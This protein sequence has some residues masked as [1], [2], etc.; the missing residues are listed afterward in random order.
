MLRL[1]FALSLLLSALV[2]GSL[3]AQT[4]A[5]DVLKAQGLQGIEFKNYV[6]PHKVIESR[7]SIQGIGTELGRQI[8]AGALHAEY[9]QKYRIVR[10]HDAAPDKLSADLL[11]L[12][13]DA[14]VDNIRNLNWIVS[15]YL[16]QEFGYAPADADLLSDFVTRYNAFY[17]GKLD[18]IQATFIPA[19]G[20]NVTAENA[21]IALSY[22][23]WPGKT[24]LLIP[25]R[26]SL[27]KGLAGGLNTEEVS[28][29]EIVKSMDDQPALDERKKL[30]DLKEAEIVQEQKAIVQAETKA[31]T[32]PGTTPPS[33]TTNPPA[34]QASTAPAAAPATSAPASAP[35]PAATPASAAAPVATPTPAPALPLDQAKQQLAARDQALQAERQDIVQQETKATPAPAPTPAPTK[36]ASTAAFVKMTEGSKTG[37]L[38][39]LDTAADKV[40][41]KSQVNSIRQ[42]NAPS[43]GAG[44][45]VVAGD[46]KVDNGAIRLLILSPDD[47]A[48][49]ATGTDD[50]VADTP[51]VISGNQVLALVK[52]TS[53]LV[54]AAFDTSLKT[55]AKGTDAL[56]SLTDVV[57]TASGIYVQ[58]AGGTVLLL[59]PTTLKKKAALGE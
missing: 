49:L 30:A 24:R 53:G 28:N 17:R 31:P 50:V 37:Q 4:V 8:K 16:Q 10:V 55:V 56:S 9:G 45:L 18:Y 48:I 58:A 15:A 34:A 59:D 42:S 41:K 5:E 22:T 6:G 33:P 12:G 26:D 46:T 51:L 23:D 21:G 40:W 38:W 20:E 39:I 57:P 19:V 1:R 35:A 43:F 36:P 13:P 29:K 47:G 2:G 25:L 44:V 3:T 52:G 54:L 32:T 7:V 14:G 27:S 11:I